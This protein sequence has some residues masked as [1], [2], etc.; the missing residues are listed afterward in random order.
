MTILSAIFRP[1]SRQAEETPARKYAVLKRTADPFA[2][3][4]RIRGAEWEHRDRFQRA[5]DAMDG[6]DREI[7]RLQAVNDDLVAQNQAL[8]DSAELAQSRADAADANAL[9][10]QAELTACILDGRAVAEERA[11]MLDALKKARD[12][13]DVM[14]KV[15]G[16]LWRVQDVRIKQAK[17]SLVAIDKVLKPP[18]K[19]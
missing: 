7:A 1:F 3:L 2:R 5:I 17:E 19:A 4:L 11:D 14:S 16:P 10:I 6:Q 15:S 8:R 13:A 18:A 9:D 12:V